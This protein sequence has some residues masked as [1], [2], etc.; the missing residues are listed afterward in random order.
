MIKEIKKFKKEKTLQV[1]R[2]DDRSIFNQMSWNLAS[3]VEPE[4]PQAG[5]K[6]HVKALLKR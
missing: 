3:E 5:T 6:S 2:C 1:D 4:L